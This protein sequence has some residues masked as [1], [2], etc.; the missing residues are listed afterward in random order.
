[1]TPAPVWP[2]RMRQQEETAAAV[3]KATKQQPF[4]QVGTTLVRTNAHGVLQ[5]AYFHLNYSGPPVQ[6]GIPSERVP[7]PQSTFM[8]QLGARLSQSVPE[9]W[10]VFPA[11]LELDVSSG[12]GQRPRRDYNLHWF[13]QAVDDELIE[14][15][16]GLIDTVG[17]RWFKKFE[18]VDRALDTLDSLDVTATQLVGR[19]PALVA[20][21]LRAERGDRVAAQRDL[22]RYLA[23]RPNWHDV[24]LQRLAERVSDYGLT[25]AP[26]D[27]DLS[28]AANR[29]RYDMGGLG[30]I[31]RGRESLREVIAAGR[32]LTAC[33]VSA[34]L[35]TFEGAVMGAWYSLLFDDESLHER[36]SAALD[37]AYVG[38]RNQLA[39]APLLVSSIVHSEAAALPIL[40]RHTRRTS[41]GRVPDG[42]TLAALRHLG[43]ERFEE[44]PTDQDKERFAAMLDVANHLRAQRFVNP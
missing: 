28:G 7:P 20:M 32:S 43:D 42:F 2:Q 21:R 38:V 27:L 17:E 26:R 10:R 25:V 3:G 31:G 9:H 39:L 24:A 19:E 16:A 4:D 12:L 41:R 6:D 1:M 35:E 40:R 18:S 22:D 8:V 29:F 36:V 14:R 15:I 13:V 11:D 23:Q 30:A 33:D 34:L 44:E 37:R 5:V